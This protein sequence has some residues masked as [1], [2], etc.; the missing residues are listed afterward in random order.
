[1]NDLKFYL[2]LQY[3]YDYYILYNDNKNKIII[4]SWMT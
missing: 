4:Q 3:V 1:M 2:Q